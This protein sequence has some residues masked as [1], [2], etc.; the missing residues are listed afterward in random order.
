MMIKLSGGA[1]LPS[2]HLTPLANPLV[3]RTHGDHHHHHHHHHHKKLCH[4]EERNYQMSSSASSSPSCSNYPMMIVIKRWAAPSL[5][6]PTPWPSSTFPTHRWNST[7]PPFKKMI[8]P[9][10][11]LDLKQWFPASLVA[12][13]YIASLSRTSKAF[14]PGGKA[15]WSTIPITGL[16]HRSR[17]NYVSQIFGNN[18]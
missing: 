10:A 11:S 16:V 5:A 3:R 12:G 6:N 13:S 15:L 4:A 2:C 17:K 18:V 8:S 14:P 1:L 9:P 7:K